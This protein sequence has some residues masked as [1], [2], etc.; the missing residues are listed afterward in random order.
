MAGHDG[1]LSWQ[2][3]VSNCSISFVFTLKSNISHTYYILPAE[4]GLR[5]WIKH[6]APVSTTATYKTYGGQY[7]AYTAR[8]GL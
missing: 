8:E 1:T 4:T 3:F 7:L 2:S 6:H 5:E